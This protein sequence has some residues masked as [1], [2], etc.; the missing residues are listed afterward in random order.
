MFQIISGD[1][2][3]IDYQ[4]VGSGPLAIVVASMK[5]DTVAALTRALLR[6][7]SVLLYNPG[8]R[9]DAG[10]LADIAALVAAEGG[11]AFIFAADAASVP[12]LEAAAALPRNI[13]ALALY[14]PRIDPLRR[15]EAPPLHWQNA[16]MPVLVLDGEKGPGDGAA[17]AD[18]MAASL[19]NGE[20]IT[21]ADQGVDFDPQ[22]MA[23][24]LTVFFEMGT[25]QV[26]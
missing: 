23:P 11:A 14:Q 7:F 13:R 19:H 10:I 21:L 18:W 20:R 22:I 17:Q 24:L 1:G 6:G 5:P 12:A 15:A 4:R 26:H 16:I 25:V 9:D 3:V 8:G 2:A